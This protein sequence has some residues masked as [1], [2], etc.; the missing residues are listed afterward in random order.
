MN[1]VIKDFIKEHIS[2]IETEDW[3]HFF[4][5]LQQHPTKYL[6][7]LPAIYDILMEAD[8]NPFDTK[9]DQGDVRNVLESLGDI[10][11]FDVKGKYAQSMI[12]NELREG[13]DSKESVANIALQCGFDVYETPDGFYGYNKSDLDYVILNPK[14][15]ALKYWYRWNLEAEGIDP[16]D[17]NYEFDSSMY[18][19]LISIE[20]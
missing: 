20:E 19:K 17:P 13:I 18:S 1:P 8:I 14:Y 16:D 2:L 6:P 12:D 10:D 7:A 15:V 11:G 9:L 3:R 4:F 5:F